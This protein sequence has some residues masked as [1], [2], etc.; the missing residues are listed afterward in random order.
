MYHAVVARTVRALFTRINQGDWQA[1]VDM[2]APR[3]EYRF[4]GDTAISGRRTTRA[5]MEAWWPRLFRLF[6]EARFEVLDVLVAGPPWA[7]R[8]MTRVVI[9]ARLA[10][11]EAYENEFMQAIRLRWGR[12]VTVTTIED[13]QR[14]AAALDRVAAAGVTEAAAAPIEDAAERPRL[15][16]LAPS[17]YCERARWAL[18]RAGIVHREERWAPGPH[19]VLARRLVSG[20]TATPILDLGGG[21]VIQG[22]ARIVDWTEL[23]G[24]DAELERRL[25]RQTAV[26]VRQLLYAALLGNPRSGVRDALLDGVS[27]G[28]ALAGRLMWPSTRRIMMRRLDA[29]PGVITKLLEQV[30]AEL[31][32]FDGVLDERGER[33]FGA[34]F[35]RTDLTAASLLAPLARPPACP[36]HALY[37]GVAYP[38]AV[39][40][41]LA[42][43]ARRPSLMWVCRV[44]AEYRHVTAASAS[45]RRASGFA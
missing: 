29:R 40:Q 32:W 42:R 20:S 44:Y 31:A 3:F 33:L 28:Q 5:A 36:V 21:E 25:E 41:A 17:H 43:W 14:V 39:E 7:T 15:I 45:S 13:T 10:N 23:P 12:I 11:D 8:V 19:A 18:D 16:V 24:G 4:L 6:P 9:R 2:L 27:K 35:G 30:E 26:L 1:M 22:S 38:P 34:A 37:A